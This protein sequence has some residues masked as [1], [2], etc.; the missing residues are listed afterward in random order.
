VLAVLIGMNMQ[1]FYISRQISSMRK[2]IFT[3]RFMKEN[4]GDLHRMEVKEEIQ[5]MGYPDAGDNLYSQ[6]LSYR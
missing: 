2:E 4:F 5:H 6:K 3:E 1:I